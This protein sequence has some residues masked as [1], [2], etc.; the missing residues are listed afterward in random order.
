MSFTQSGNTLRFSADGLTGS[1]TTQFPSGA[2]PTVIRQLS[3]GTVAMSWHTTLP[4]I[5][6][7]FDPVTGAERIENVIVGDTMPMFGGQFYEDINF[8]QIAGLDG[9]NFV[10]TYEI[11]PSRDNRVYFQI[12]GP[13]GSK[14]GPE[15]EF[16]D[17]TATSVPNTPVVV[18]TGPGFLMVFESGDDDYDVRLFDGSGTPVGPVTTIDDLDEFKIGTPGDGTVI[19]IGNS[20]FSTVRDNVTWPVYRFDTATGTQIGETVLFDPALDFGAPLTALEVEDI[21]AR[22]GGGHAIL[23]S[24]TYR[25]AAAGFVTR[26]FVELYDADGSTHRSVPTPREIIVAPLE[27]DRQANA[28][29]VPTQDGG[30]AVLFEADGDGTDR[31]IFG[32]LY[33]AS[34]AML[35]EVTRLSENTVGDQENLDAI[36]LSDGRLAMSYTDDFDRGLGE[37]RVQIFTLEQ[38]DPP[39]PGSTAGNDILIGTP[40]GDVFDGLAGDDRILGLAGADT[41]RGGAD[42]DT[43]FGDGALARYYGP[44][45]ANAVYRIYQAALNRQPDQAGHLDWTQRLATG[46]TALSQVSAGFVG[47][48][49]FQNVY[50]TL[51]DT[52]FVELLYQNVLGRAADSGGLAGWLNQLIGAGRDG[53]TGTADDVA[54]TSR[55]DVVLGFSNARE[56]SNATNV[57]ANAFAQESDPASW[58][59]DVYRLYQATLGRDPDAPGLTSWAELLGSGARSLTEVATGFVDSREFQNVYGALDDTGFVGLLYQN[60]L[61]RPAQGGEERGWLDLLSGAGQDGVTGTADDVTPVGRADIVLGFSQSREFIN[62]TAPA[63]KNWV[64]DQGSHD[65][66]EAGPGK[67]LV[68]GGMFAD[69]FVFGAGDVGQTTVADFEAWDY[70]QF[71]GFGYTQLADVTGRM[72]Q[73]GNDLLFADK[74]VSVLLTD[75]RLEDIA[76]DTFVDTFTLV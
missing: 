59:D 10:A 22:P 36:L 18:S 12:Y 37:A 64:R 57:Q 74:G 58:T 54:P 39:P 55:A 69:T 68:A 61:G 20:S 28:Q 73:M 70:L 30:Y 63:V 72:T 62:V 41:L 8:L 5:I 49:E 67:N 15:V 32:V 40:E 38:G 23:Y 76:I 16:L 6:E 1:Q 47:S 34:E 13:D 65:R 2:T 56:F 29:V 48:R 60:V 51:S 4:G 27:I 75:T 43:L 7:L 33:D 24:G 14:I 71:D 25:D 52:G 66:I 9:G 35:G 42:D 50:G 26:H 3:D 31:D 45:F 19:F 17:N 44:E 46:E 21:S 11:E 53:M